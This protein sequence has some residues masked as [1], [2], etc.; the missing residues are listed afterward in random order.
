[1][2]LRGTATYSQ[3]SFGGTTYH[4]FANFLDD[5]SGTGSVSRD[6]GEPAYYP[7]LFRQAYFVQDR[8]Q[9]RDNFT[10]SMGLRWED[11]GTPA[12]SLRTP[13]Y[14]GIFNVQV[15]RANRTWTAPMT[16]PNRTDRDLNNFA[17]NI[18]LTYSP[19][20][21]SG[22]LGMLFGQ[23]KTVLRSGY[24]IGYDSFF[25]NIASNAAS[26]APNMVTTTVVGQ[27]TADTPRGIA[28]FSSQIPTT[29]RAVLPIDGQNLVV[30]EL[31]NPY[32]QRWSFG[33]Q[34]E[35]P[36][37][38]ILETSYVGSSGTHLFINEDLNPQV[39]DPAR[40]VLPSGFTSIADLQSALPAGYTLQPRLDPLQGGRTI[41]TNAGHSSYHAL[42]FDFNKRF[43]RD[44]GFRASYTWS[45]M[46]DNASEIFTYNNTSS[47]AA[48]PSPFGGQPLERAVSL[49]DRTH[50]F[51][52][53]YTYELPFLRSQ[54]G[55]VG[56]VLGGWQ[57]AGIATLQTGVPYSVSNGQDADGLGGANDRP[58]VNPNGRAGVRARLDA[59]SPTGY[60]NPD[61]LDASGRPVSI[62]PAEARYIGVPAGSGRTGNAG[63]N[64]ERIPGIRNWNTNL[65]KNIR[66]T[67]RFN[68]QFRTEFFNVLNHP[69]YGYPSIS[70][71]T[72]GEGTIASNVF[73]SL[74]GR[75]MRPEFMDG[76]GRTVRYQLTLRF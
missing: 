50:A 65:M 37:Q 27:V 31:K 2:Y 66:V 14:A 15:N 55:L 5:Y 56:R 40:R 58:D 52:F 48:V 68:L 9:I 59:S 72:P 23:R 12:N 47:L 44:L 25:N 7:E 62:N 10:L 4:A 24:Q 51:T 73:G 36:W 21:D 22:V 43:T 76:G 17:P 38:T 53:S 20:F 11:F 70:P 60:V 54:Q 45:K 74:A 6:F 18:G 57:V 8:W 49:Y 41:R 64:T 29:P 71:F 63:R 69:Q 67:E 30:K 19:S 42:Q 26:S 28:S 35:L 1:V 13:A 32:T 34:R 39:V 61:V 33:F 75:F 3:S 46:I 16:E